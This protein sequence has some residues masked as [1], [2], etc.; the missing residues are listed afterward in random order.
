MRLKEILFAVAVG[1]ASGVY[2]WMPFVK[3][4]KKIRYDNT[5]Y[6]RI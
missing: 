2:I 1:G 3:E 5:A 4:M 6:K